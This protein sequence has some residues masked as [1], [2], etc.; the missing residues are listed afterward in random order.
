VLIDA[1][2]F[3]LMPKD[4][5]ALLRAAAATPAFLDRFPLPVS[6]LKLG[7]RQVFHDQ[8]LL[9]DERCA[10][11]LA[12]LRRSGALASARAMMASAR[13]T[14]D[15]FQ[16]AA[17]RV[18]AKTLVLWGKGDRWIPASDADRFTAAIA[19]SKK[20]MIDACGHIPHEEKPAET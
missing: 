18:K 15:Q 19:G 11:Y 2:G 8:A 10:E 17:T 9:T 20:V 7:L 16:D 4:R 5:P 6:V 3:N 1:A 13:I 14:P 12:P